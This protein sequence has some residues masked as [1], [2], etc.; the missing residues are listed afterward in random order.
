MRLSKTALRPRS[1]K[2]P[3]LMMNI[4]YIWHDCF[5]LTTESATLI[6]DYWKEPDGSTPQQS[7]LND[8]DSQ[9]PVYVF[10][11]HHHK[12]HLN[13]EIFGWG[14]ILPDIHY[15][16][17]NDT[18]KFCRHYLRPDSFCRGDKPAP[19]SVTVLRPGESWSDGTVNVEAFGS[20]DIGNSYYVEVDGHSIFHAGDLNAWI[21]IDESSSEEVE[22]ALEKFKFIL[23]DIAVRHSSIDYVMFPVDPRLGT[24]YWTGAEIFVREIDCRHF[25]PMHFTLGE[26]QQ[27]CRDFVRGASDFGNYANPQRGEY[28]ILTEP[29]KQFAD[30][31]N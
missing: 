30:F 11:S 5:I 21:W 16:I 24:R 13:P 23:H 10:V 20:T 7:F 12:D 18:A 2:P 4:K 9:K 22:Q 14:N 28:I 25:F 1:L 15:I 27:Q 17:S 8:I 19:E 26:N 6:F 31:N 29:H 3:T